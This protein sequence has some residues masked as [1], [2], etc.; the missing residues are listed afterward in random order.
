MNAMRAWSKVA[1][2]KR[3]QD[4]VLKQKACCYFA[5]AAKIKAGRVAERQDETAIDW[6][7]KKGDEEE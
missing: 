3:P 4:E 6:S 7:T 1:I 5:A 2:A